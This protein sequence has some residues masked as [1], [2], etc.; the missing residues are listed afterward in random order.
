VTK[1]SWT[2]QIL[3]IMTAFVVT[4]CAAKKERTSPVAPNEPAADGSSQV[5]IY[6]A[7][8]P[9]RGPSVPELG[10]GDAPSL[11]QPV[12]DC[13]ATVCAGSASAG[14]IEAVRGRA[15]QARSC[16]EKSLSKTPTL[17]GRMLLNLRIAHDGASC[18]F[19]VAQNELSGSSTLMPCLR[20][21]L[22]THYPR[23]TGGCVELNLPL[24]FVPEYIDADAGTPA[25]TPVATAR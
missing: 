20:A 13:D 18:P 17:G 11:V 1:P 15:A 14:L 24:K 21:V 2:R 6:S 9:Q 12:N 5:R 8:Q 4:S 10:K 19:G 22:E 23:P 16:Y 7:S 3:A 25:A